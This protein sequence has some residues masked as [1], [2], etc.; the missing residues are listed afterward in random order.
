MNSPWLRLTALASG[1]LVVA[2]LGRAL[3]FP[4]DGN[5]T[6]LPTKTELNEDALDKPR[7]VFQSERVGAKSYMVNLGDLAFNSPSILGEVARQAGVSCGTCH[8]NG[9]GN[10]RFFMPKMS[11]RP[12]NFDVTGPLFNPKANN[13]VLDPV[14]IPSLRGARYLAPYGSDGRSASLRDFIRNVIVNEF[15]GPEPS[16]A[17]IDAIVAYVQDIDFL[18]NPS[19]GPGGRLVGNVSES[20]RRGEALFSKPFPHDPGLSCA[21]CHVP[22]AAFV[23]HQQHDVGSGGLFKTPTLRNADFNAP[24]FHDGRFDGFDQVVDHFDRAFDLDLSSQDKRDLVA[25]LTAVGDGVQPYERDG[26]GA[27]LKEIN[28]FNMVLATAIPSGDKAIVALAVDTIGRELRELTERYP[29]RK[30]TS[31]SGGEQQRVR[32]RN[33]LKELVLMLR[34]IDIAVAEGR[35]ADA[36]TEFRNYRY[37]MAAAVPALLAGAEPWSLFNQDVHDQHYAALRQVMQSKH[38]SH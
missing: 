29:D 20:E 16:P 6:V 14:R 15:A 28:D 11:T 12:G 32:A 18:P 26:A 9:V 34:R 3:A 36:A 23:D 10:A 7:E 25:Y 35:S 4:V 17:I 1:L 13:L 5:Q 2:S 21:G 8:V 22:S 38:L 37:L 31:V 24:Y 19:L 33:S 27:A 30:N